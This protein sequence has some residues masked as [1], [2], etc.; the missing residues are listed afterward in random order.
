MDPNE[1]KNK[2]NIINNLKSKL[3]K[4]ENK[5]KSSSKQKSLTIKTEKKK[6]DVKKKSKKI[7]KSKKSEMNVKKDKN[8]KS[9]NITKEHDE[10][11]E[12]KWN[13]FKDKENIKKGQFT[14]EETEKIIDSICQYA[15]DNSLTQSDL[16]NLVTEK[17]S[18]DKSIWPKIAECLPNRSVQSIHNFCHRVLNPFNYKGAW[19]HEEEKKLIE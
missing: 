4:N 2:L 19:T 12:R 16:I 10:T 7:D 18:K 1:L 5:T 11:N 17:Q 6:K 8:E 3:E 13:D 9:S 14:K 15:Y